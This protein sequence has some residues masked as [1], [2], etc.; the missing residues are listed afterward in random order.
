MDKPDT[1]R[2]LVTKRIVIIKGPR[3]G[4]SAY[5]MMIALNAEIRSMRRRGG[6]HHIEIEGRTVKAYKRMRSKSKVGTRKVQV[7]QKTWDLV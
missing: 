5:Q 3:L 7:I 4:S 1:G 2:G 6:C